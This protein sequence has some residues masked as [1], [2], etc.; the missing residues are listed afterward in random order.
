LTYSALHALA[1]AAG[2]PHGSGDGSTTFNVPDLRGRTTVGK[3]DMGGSAAGRISAG[4][5]GL[6]LGGSNGAE[7]H[8]LVA[9]QMPSHGHT[10]NS[11]AHGGGNHGHGITDNGHTHQISANT[12]STM[13]NAGGANG[14]TGLTTYPGPQNA[15]AQIVGTG[16]SINA[17]GNTIAAES[18]GTTGAGGDQAHNNLQP[19]Q[20]VNKIVK[21]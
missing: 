7:N 13:N 12:T 4:N 16:I 1:L 14:L 15:V 8:T 6:T 19:G 5:N 10:V 18:P 2:Y 9:G 21:T 17:S 3:D 11:H 20:I